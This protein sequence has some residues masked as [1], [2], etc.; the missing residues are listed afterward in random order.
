MMDRNFVL[1][2]QRPEDVYE[3]HCQVTQLPDGDRCIVD[4]HCS[5]R[6]DHLFDEKIA[7]RDGHCRRGGIRRR[8]AG[9]GISRSAVGD[10][11]KAL[12]ESGL[13]KKLQEARSAIALDRLDKAEPILKQVL[14]S[15]ALWASR[16]L[17]DF[18]PKALWPPSI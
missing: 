9:D 7:A 18:K 11:K 4:H 1:K 13:N 10:S 3:G 2:S 6:G 17:P 16:I 14:E 5:L 8:H 12:V 15:T